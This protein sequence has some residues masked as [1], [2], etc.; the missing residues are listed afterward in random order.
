MVEV[1]IYTSLVVGVW[2]FG[3][4]HPLSIFVME[5]LGVLVAGG[6]LLREWISRGVRGGGGTGFG[7]GLKTSSKWTVSSYFLFTGAL[8]GLLL[9]LLGLISALNA[10]ARFDGENLQF[11]YFEEAILWLPH[12]YDQV[13]SWSAL[14]IYGSLFLYFWGIRG[15]LSSEQALSSKRNQNGTSTEIDFEGG[16]PVRIKTLLTVLLVNGALVGFVGVLQRLGSNERLLWILEPAF[17][18]PESHFGPFAY[19]GN[20]STYFN[21]LWPIAFYLLVRLRKE[22]LLKRSSD[23]FGSGGWIT[24]VPVLCLFSV[25]PWM[26]GSRGGSTVFVGVFVMLAIWLL[27]SSKQKIPTVIGIVGF[28]GAISLGL[29][30][31]G[32]DLLISRIEL[33]LGEDW[34]VRGLDR[35]QLY[36]N[37]LLIAEDHFV[38]GVGPG[39]FSSVYFSYRLPE[40]GHWTNTHLESWAA[41]GHSD[42]L[43]FLVTFGSVG[44]GLIMVGFFALVLVPMIV[45]GFGIMRTPVFIL[46]AGIFGF[47]AHSCIDFPFQVYSLHHVFLVVLAVLTV[48]DDP[49]RTPSFSSN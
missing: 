32:V 30:L 36:R 13:Q 26:A 9:L 18:N 47:C 14:M 16:L 41:W 25:V 28:A 45:H 7:A 46:Y 1:L 44:F 3:T 34:A 43:E 29:W 31:V 22:E 33:T 11:E 39:S 48:T 40:V 21:L 12:S 20:A 42:P 49:R 37:M 24:L 35:G 8:S 5:I 38:W 10:R 2:A 27:K 4:V 6:W 23:R 17:K 19:R 15:W